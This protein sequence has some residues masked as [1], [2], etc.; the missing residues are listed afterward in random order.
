MVAV[1]AA[2]NQVYGLDETTI[3]D[4][5]GDVDNDGVLDSVDNCQRIA[6]PNQED[7]D[8]DGKGDA[9][10]LICMPGSGTRSN[11]DRDRDRI[12]DGCD[13]CPRSP[14]MDSQGHVLDEDGDGVYD[15]CDNCPGT[16]NPDQ[17]NDLGV[18]DELGNACDVFPSGTR[19]VFDPFWRP[20]DIWFTDW[21]IDAGV[22]VAD[23]SIST[24][25]LLRGVELVFTNFQGWVV[26]AGID[27]ST[28]TSL[29]M[30]G[31]D[32]SVGL[33]AIERTATGLQ[34]VARSTLSANTVPLSASTG[35]IAVRAHLQEAGPSTFLNCSAA[36]ATVS[37]TV[38]SDSDYTSVPVMLYG[39]VPAQLTYVDISN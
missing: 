23:P 6:N 29:G 5:D 33:C 32:V 27:V 31:I 30:I 9:C 22:V 19:V 24:K 7:V 35:V 21:K 38:A 37:A 36:G 28:L 15:A 1:L 34:L 4:N 2:C 12:D 10:A 17:R 11:T 39:N 26:D 3:G 20:Q 13:P 16:P 14:Q 8:G 18:A 25:M